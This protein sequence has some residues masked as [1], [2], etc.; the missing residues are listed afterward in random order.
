[1]A[2]RDLQTVLLSRSTLLLVTGVGVGLMTLSYV[3]GVQVGKQSAALR[4][5]SARG[6]GAE[7]Q[8]L[9]MSM[10]EQLKAFEELDRIQRTPL[11]SKQEAKT[12]AKPEEAAAESKPEA[13]PASTSTPPAPN[14]PAS[15]AP[16]LPATP[17]APP[18]TKKAAPGSAE[19]R[20]TLQLVATPDAA[21]AMRVAN[22]AKAAGFAT[23]TLREQ[24]QFK[25]RLA[26]SLP[27]AEADA[28][29][30][31]LKAK[32]IKSFPLQSH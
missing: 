30:E 1:M 8:E 26:Q 25:V 15:T 31:K 21:E 29:A 28:T 19:L 6:A 20:W 32:G 17:P 9:P 11:D 27:K 5:N 24:N 4:R 23:T 10:E 14:A 16:V 7:L 12:D 3:L 18:E 2:D 22:K 13:K